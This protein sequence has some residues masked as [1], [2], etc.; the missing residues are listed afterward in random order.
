VAKNL[1]RFVWDGLINTKTKKIKLIH[2]KI[3]LSGKPERGIEK[4]TF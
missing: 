2:K 3:P 4:L 1:P